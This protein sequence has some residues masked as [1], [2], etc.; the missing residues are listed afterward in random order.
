MR[1]LR[2]APRTLALRLCLY[3]GAATCTVL[4][5]TAW[6]DYRASQ[7]ALEEQTDGEARKQVQAAAQD[8][9]D[10]VGKVAILPSSIAARQKA[11]G[12]EPDPLLLP[13]LVQLL[14]EA[15]P[16]GYGVYLAFV[17]KY[18]AEPDSVPTV[19]GRSR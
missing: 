4:A 19:R 1:R 3:I 11:I 2:L 16:E 6:I 15:P 8:L 17:G 14:Q 18:W 7:A 9:D 5:A 10:F 13:Y 12:P